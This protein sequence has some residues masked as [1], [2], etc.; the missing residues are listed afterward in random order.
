MNKL[1]AVHLLGVSKLLGIERGA[2]KSQVMVKLLSQLTGQ[3]VAAGLTALVLMGRNVRGK[4][5]P[6]PSLSTLT[7]I[8][9]GSVKAL[10]DVAA[11]NGLQLQETDTGWEAVCAPDF[12]VSD[13]DNNPLYAAEA[14]TNVRS[15]TPSSR[16]APRH[17]KT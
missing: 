8:G 13:A 16:V 9:Y 7:Q 3:G 11:A 10:S 14:K 4:A 15:G 12:L 1:R 2:G 17:S 5:I 6:L